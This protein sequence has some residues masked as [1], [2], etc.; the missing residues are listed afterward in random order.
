MEARNQREKL[1][2]KIIYLKGVGTIVL[3]DKSIRDVQI[4]AMFVIH[5]WHFIIHHDIDYP[6]HFSV[7]EASTGLSVSE[8]CYPEPIDAYNSVA[9]YLES[10]KYYLSTTTGNLL[11]K[12][13]T[14]LF[15]HNSCI[16]PLID[17]LWK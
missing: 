2:T 5:G 1:T 10:V 11:V 15:N 8:Y 17:F 14:N 13:Q 16:I 3:H 6:D 9:S 4:A 7:S 12:T